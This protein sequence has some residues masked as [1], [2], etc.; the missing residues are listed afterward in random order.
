MHKVSRK[1]TGLDAE[2]GSSDEG[3][4]RRVPHKVFRKITGLDAQ[5]PDDEGVSHVPLPRNAPMTSSGVLPDNVVSDGEE[6][7]V[8]IEGEDRHSA[9]AA[10][11]ADFL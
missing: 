8:A 7:G 4:V 10:S 1:F 6:Q 11:A 2:Q 5:S 3:G 9:G